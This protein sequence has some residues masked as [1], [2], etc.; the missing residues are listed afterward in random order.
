MALLIF[1]VN[2]LLAQKE[3]YVE[4]LYLQSYNFYVRKEICMEPFN[5]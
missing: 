5:F 2:A 4:P 3:S 1:K